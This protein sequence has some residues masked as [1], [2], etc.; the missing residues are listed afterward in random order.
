MLHVWDYDVNKLK[1]SKRGRLLLLERQ[2][3]YGVY[4]KDKEKI[5]LQEVKKNWEILNIEKKRRR[6]LQYLI[7]NK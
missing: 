3:D 5:D 7:W 6:F 4:L 1:K 2:I